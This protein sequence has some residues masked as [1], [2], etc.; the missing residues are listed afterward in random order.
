MTDYTNLKLREKTFL[1]FTDDAAILDEII[2]GHSGA[3]KEFFL[4][5][6]SPDNSPAS[7]DNRTIT[8]MAFADLCKDEQLVQAIKAE[9]ENEYRSIFNE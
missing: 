9:F 8:F 7:E 4:Q 3:D 2:E 6:V 5:S 1:D